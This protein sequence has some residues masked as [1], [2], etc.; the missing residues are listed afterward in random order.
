[1][2]ALPET[3]EHVK[4]ALVTPALCVPAMDV[5]LPGFRNMPEVFATA[6]MVAFIELACIEAL[7]PY[8]A[9]DERTLGTALNVT[10]RAATPVGMRVTARVRLH[11]R[12]GRRLLFHIEC[13]DE[14]EPIGAGKHERTLV[15]LERFRERLEHKRR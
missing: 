15:D 7:A 1:M 3:L 11:A 12:H 14:K 10:H 5:V 4:S 6:K 8:L 13:H 9:G 2:K